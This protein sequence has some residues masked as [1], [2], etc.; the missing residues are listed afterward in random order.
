MKV[1]ELLMNIHNK[2]FNLER[3]LQVK[4]YL[5]M[6]TKK[7]IAQG[8]IYE[9]TTGEDGFIK[10][11]S[12][13]QYMSYVKYM[14]TMHTNLEY[15]SENYDQLCSTQYGET[16]LLNA[17]IDCFSLDAKECDRIVNMTVSDYIQY[18]SVEAQI[19]K[20]S[21]GLNDV[22]E[23]LKTKINEFDTKSI[24]PEGLDVD[25]LNHFLTKYVK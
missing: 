22:L 2:E 8:I 10:V 4:K 1:N 25:R 9:C 24:I 14:I 6:E 16:N 21:K 12:V 18:N 19:G 23:S 17:I 15:T 5:P 13:Q 20:I 11:D 3:G 7:T